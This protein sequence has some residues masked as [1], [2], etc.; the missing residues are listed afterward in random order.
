MAEFDFENLATLKVKVT[1]K[2]S[3]TIH[4]LK[5]PVE[6][7]ERLFLSS[8]RQWQQAENGSAN[9]LRSHLMYVSRPSFSHSLPNF[10]I[11]LGTMLYST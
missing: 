5:Y 1:N 11:D 10:R 6:G 3:G 2:Q 8:G 7:F 9:Q 4:K